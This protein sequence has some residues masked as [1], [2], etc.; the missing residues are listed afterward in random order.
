MTAKHYLK[1][2]Q[3]AQTNIEILAEE[4]ERQRAR[5][6]ST[7]APVLGDRVQTSPGG[8]RFAD[9][10]A[11][12]ADREQVYQD[13]LYEYEILREK[14]VR[15]ILDLESATQSQVLYQRYVKGKALRSISEELHYEYKYLCKVH[16]RA[17]LA[18]AE[19]YPEILA[20]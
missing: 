15:Q 16:G 19:A 8:D 10:I 5:L 7:A 2:L 4:I 9:L 11:G 12:L 20:K 6:E 3:K 14:I 17:L 18:F 1:Q 13:M